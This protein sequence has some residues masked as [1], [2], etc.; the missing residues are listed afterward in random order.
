MR[1]RSIFALLA[2]MCLMMMLLTGCT[3]ASIVLFSLDDHIVVLD[4]DLEGNAFRD[5]TLTVYKD[6]IGFHLLPVTV[7]I[8]PL[9]AIG[10]TTTK[11]DII[12]TLWNLTNKSSVNFKDGFIW[13]PRLSETLKIG[14]LNPV[15]AELYT[16]E[17]GPDNARRTP[18]FVYFLVDN[19]TGC[20][21]YNPNTNSKAFINLLNRIDVIP[22]KDAGNYFTR[23]WGNQ[24]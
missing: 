9:S 15:D 13:V 4:Q 17:F 22:K 8:H 21:I 11:D 10:D 14:K 18:Y 23:L 6:E 20:R 16:G 1:E 2:T 3:S 19:N 24:E 12:I 7:D 5:I